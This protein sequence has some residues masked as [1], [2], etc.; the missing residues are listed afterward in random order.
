MSQIHAK[1]SKV[2]KAPPEPVYAV[3]GDYNES[4]PAIL[5]KRVF[6]GLVVEQG[7]IGAGTVVRVTM[8][9]LDTTQELHVEEILNSERR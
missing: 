8:A 3:I 6:S 7:G 4:H 1:V 5:P 9:A 2:I